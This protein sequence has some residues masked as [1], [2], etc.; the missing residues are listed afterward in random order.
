MLELDPAKYL[1]TTLRDYATGVKPGLP[2]LFE[3][4]LL[5]PSDSDNSAIQARM[6]EVKT[7]WDKSLE[8]S[9]YGEVARVLAA[10][11]DD[12]TLNLLDPTERARLATEATREIEEEEERLKRAAGEW[13]ALLAEH[14]AKG[15]LTPNSRTM[16][17]RL[18]KSLGVDAALATAELDRAPIAAAPEVMPEDVRAKIQRSLQDL[19]RLVGEERLAL[20]LYHAIGL[21]GIT[22]DLTQVRAQYDDVTAENQGRGYGQMATNYKTVLANVKLY[23]LDADPRAY[24]EGLMQDVGAAME[25]EVARSATDDV[26]DPTEARQL[27]E[28]AI[29][30]GLTPELARRLI[31]DLARQHGARLEVGAIVDYVA[32]P[33]CNTPHDR[34]TAPDRCRRCGA[35]LFIECPADGCST[36]NDAVALCCSVCQTD[37]FKF[38]EATRRLKQLP[39]AVDEG[40]VGWA[41]IELVAIERVLGAQAIPAD[42]RR[43][44]DGL[45]SDAE[46]AW[47]TV[48]TAMGERRLFSARTALREL[49]RAAGD[50]AGPTGDL[51]AK[52]ADEVDRRLAEV[53][54]ALARAR[55][56]SGSDREKALVEVVGL[57]EDCEE[58]VAALATIPPAP[59]TSVRV[60]MGVSGPI[61]EWTASTTSGA[62][63]VVRR[64]VGGADHV[65]LPPTP[66]TQVEDRNAPTGVRVS[67]EVATAR[68][69]ATSAFA[70]SSALVVAREVED[71]SVA[72][73]DH[74]VRL[75]W[76]AV[77]ASAR[78]VVTRTS[79][80]SGERR[81]L[82]ADR[83]GVV[84]TEVS[85]GERYGYE[86]CVEY[87]SETRTAGVTIYGQPSAPPEGIEQ[88]RITNA[89]GGVLVNFDRPANGNVSIL[90]C[91]AEPGV[92][93]GEVLDPA[94]L[95]SIGRTLPMG[96]DGARDEA[97]SGVCW[98]LPV[99]TAGGS[100]VAG[101]ATRHLALAEIGN[102]TVAVASGQARVTWEWPSDVRIAK[103][104]WRT[105]RQPS[106]PDEPD[107]DSAWVRLGEYRDLG[108]FTI[109][110]RAGSLFVAVVPGLRLDGELVSG[111]S[112]SRRSR[113][114]VTAAARTDLQYVI[115]RSGFKGKKLEIEVSAPDG[116]TPPSLI[117]VARPGDL[118]PRAAAEGDVLARLGGGAAL[119]SSISLAGR[120]RPLALR[121]FLESASSA[122]AFQ[123][124]DPGVDDLLVR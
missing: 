82:L 70:A 47:S 79:E 93:M 89:H 32:C 30:R 88:L 59:P 48:E 100:A 108:G 45:V 2:G 114:A 11:H 25:F 21:E 67:Y 39:E 86:V 7:I 112:L 117:L 28:T 101:R 56:L 99:T 107:A 68:G 17:E 78:V 52:R 122:T 92:T 91:D 83:T 38:A 18:A 96:A 29:R 34:T 26:I 8:H 71:W 12:A 90:R 10:E 16:L 6:D 42:L 81:E 40:R 44:L 57:A 116:V 69:R 104:V 103:V 98:Y 35:A 118:L 62:T 87:G 74:E 15:G 43:R 5:E 113:G 20:S 121:L 115:R 63:Y 36:R 85:N 84:D 55:A 105:D 65:E 33:A 54:A 49:V 119:K 51:P 95:A 4:Y 23:L 37:L 60:S 97:Q 66:S 73:G 46:A 19:A 120:S 41:A 3:R 50:V 24:I 9:R 111:T 31:T 77:P 102:V 13:R 53:D 64:V 14:V 75:S 80:R 109:A 61:V 22:A 124:V 123:L 72:D 1:P 106:S 94:G 110:H 58:A 27:E 76:S